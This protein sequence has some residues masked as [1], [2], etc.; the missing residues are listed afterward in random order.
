MGLDCSGF[1]QVVMSLFGRQLLRNASEQVTQGQPVPDLQH[2]QAG[3]LVF[4][5]HNDGRIS[6][7]GI[8]LHTASADLSIIHC[9]GRVKVERLDETGIF[10]VERADKDHPEGL[11]THHLVAIRRM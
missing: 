10:S 6:H 9:S 11:Y 2:A 7:V 4:F 8:I 5:D 3:D 1:T